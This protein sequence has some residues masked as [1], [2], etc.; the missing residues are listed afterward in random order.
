MSEPIWPRPRIATSLFA[1]AV[2]VVVEIASAGCRQSRPGHV[3][4]Q[5]IRIGISVGAATESVADSGLRQVVEI[6]TIESLVRLGE[7]GRPRPWLAK[8]WSVTRGGN[9]VTIHL[10]P[11][12]RFH[13]GS[14][15]DATVVSGI[16]RAQMPLRG[17]VFDIVE[18]VNPTSATDVE[19]DLRRPSPFV[20]ESLEIPIRQPGKSGAGTGPFKKAD[21]ATGSG[22]FVAN[23]SYYLGAPNIER[24]IVSPYP[25][26]R[27]AWADMLR[28][29]LDM[30]WEVGPDALSSFEGAS[31]I[32]VFPFVR[33]FQYSV[34]FNTVSS[35]FESREL[36][37]AISLGVDRKEIVHA[38][39]SDHG[40][41]SSSP[42]WPRHWAFQQDSPS[43]TYDP[44][45]A[46]QL[47]A[48]LDH[49]ENPVHF[50]CLVA[51]DFE[52]LALVIKRQLAGIGVDMHIEPASPDTIVRRLS[53]RQFEAALVDAI[54][55]PN[56]T[57][58]Y[59]WW[60]SGPM[61][62]A[63]FKSAVVDAA[64]DR[65]R[66]AGNDDEYREAVAGFQRAM[67]E[68]P[69]AVFLAWSERARAVSKRFE[70]P[71]DPGRDILATL[72]LW[73]PTEGNRASSRN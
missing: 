26:V 64:L 4:P 23:E 61:N 30:L 9:I 20:L 8:D 62:P 35:L 38:A 3:G 6:L 44:A 58:P 15:A 65:I 52:R 39:L 33:R 60:H 53:S 14:P 21:A 27:A 70:L 16:L 17:P 69:P 7:D 32:T 29:N 68:D 59:L 42:V 43:F 40:I 12:V 36:R 56:L 66:Y 2:C 28:N 24:I 31:N 37:R 25:T 46:A 54:S 22:V 13:D 45:A 41:P 71:A 11:G 72:R 47:V 67:M 48:G 49:G 34:V 50:T 5:P 73:K 63:G 51:P 55:G 10:R 1:A 57:R 19:I 18:R